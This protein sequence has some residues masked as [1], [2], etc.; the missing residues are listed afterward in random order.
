MNEIDPEDLERILEKFALDLGQAIGRSMG[1]A[2]A[3]MYQPFLSWI[4]AKQPH[5]EHIIHEDNTTKITETIE[6]KGKYTWYPLRDGGKVR[7]CN[8]EGCPWYLKYNDKKNTYEH[9]KYDPNNQTWSYIQDYC[10]FYG[11]N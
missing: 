10:D 6:K 8:N 1:E 11:G 2:I 5:L 7:K 9:G 4:E 3:K